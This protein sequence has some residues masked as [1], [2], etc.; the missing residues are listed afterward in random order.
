[1]DKSKA[2]L[3]GPEIR[4]ILEQEH[5]QEK[6]RELFDEMHPYDIFSLIED[7]PPEDIA[8]I[9]AALKEKG[10]EVFEYFSD[11]DKK[12]IF[13][14]FSRGKMVD[15]LEEMSSDE[16]A[17]FIKRLPEEIIDDILP[18][19]AQADRNDIKKLVAY[20]EGTAGAIMTT[21]YANVP[22][23]MTVEEAMDYLRKIAPNRETIYYI[24]VTDKARRLIGF[25]SLR[26]LIVA[27]KGAKI[28]D[29]MHKDVI[30]VKAS[31]P[32]TE[33]AK[34][35]SDYDF[36][37]LPVVDENDALVGIVTVDDV[38]DV[39]V[40][41]DTEDM[42]S[43]GATGVVHQ[44]LEEPVF[45]IAKKRIMWLLIL[46]FVQFISGAILQAHSA[47]LQAMIAIAF[48]IPVLSGTGGNAGSQSSTTI[49]RGLATSDISEDDMFRV[50]RKE[51]MT[52]LMVGSFLGAI[53]FFRAQI[54]EKNVLL[55][56]TVF[57][58]MVA[59]VTMATVSGAVL[60][61]LFKK[62]KLDPAL[63]SGPFIASIV[64]IVS[65][66]IYLEIARWLIGI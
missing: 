14:C 3:A 31:E 19:V 65:I 24:Y 10:I 40:E 11:E 28:E 27:R 22:P 25:V 53:G 2:S 52:G 45:G 26:E 59:T 17:D 4:E 57:L 49:I 42:L 50:F 60:P 5:Y 58:S 55:A 8:R 66:F 39:V 44:Y 56:I 48:F 62:M 64:D 18:L 29:I 61:I 13:Y 38:L 21:E 1:M 51:L 46:V 35:I 15:L 36:L 6:L 63:M 47:Q 34:K 43:Y 54:M 32:A 16:R 30:S 9:I 37:A 33:A 7:L 12:E 23:D 20:K 41:E